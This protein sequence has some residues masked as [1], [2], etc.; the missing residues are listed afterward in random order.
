MK[1]VHKKRSKDAIK[2]WRDVELIF[3]QVQQ[4]QKHERIKKA[5]PVCQVYRCSRS[6]GRIELFVTEM[7]CSEMRFLFSFYHQKVEKL[8]RSFFKTAVYGKSAC[9]SSRQ[10][11]VKTINKFGI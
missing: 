4:V 7:M 8:K 3:W 1:K 6:M 5:A 9:H 2:Y 11:T 10:K